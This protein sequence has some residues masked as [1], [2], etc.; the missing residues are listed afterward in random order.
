MKFC[1][2]CGEEISTKDGEN[3]CQACEEAMDSVRSQRTDAARR[4]AVM[5]RKAREEALR[6]CGLVKVR[7]AM[8]GT[9]WE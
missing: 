6:S 8:G 7:G 5:I 3:F 4:R 2:R 1:N 9:Y